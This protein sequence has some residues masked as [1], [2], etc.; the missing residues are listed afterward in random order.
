MPRVP[1]AIAILY[2][3]FKIG[4]IA[5]PISSNFSAGATATRIEDSEC[6][7]LFTG[8]GFQRRGNEVTLKRS[9]DEAIEQAGHVDV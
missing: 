3:C 7:I 2:D 8:D 5:V 1:E 9:A 4:A 6:R